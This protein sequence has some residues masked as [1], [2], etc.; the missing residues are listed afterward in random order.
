MED[1]DD[2]RE[3]GPGDGGTGEAGDGRSSPDDVDVE[4]E[5]VLV[6]PN[7][8]EARDLEEPGQVSGSRREAGGEGRGVGP[9][10]EAPEELL[11]ERLTNVDLTPPELSDEAQEEVDDVVEETL[12]HLVESHEFDET[13]D[14][15]FVA[16]RFFDWSYLEDELVERYWLNPP[17]A[18]TSV[19]YHEDSSTRYYHLSEPVL[20]DTEA[21]VL[22]DMREIVKDELLDES[23]T[24]D[25]REGFESRVVDVVEDYAAALPPGSRHKIAY[26]VSRDFRGYGAIDAVLRDER[27][28][29]ISAD[30]ADVPVFVYHGEYRDLPS[31]VQLD[32]RELDGLV[33]R[34][35]Q[36]AGR[37][38]SYSDPIV[39]ATLPGNHRVQLTL[40]SDVAPRG[41][42]FTVRLFTEIPFTPVDLVRNNTFSLE[43][44]AF[45]WLCIEHRQSILFVGPTASGKTTSM[46]AVSLFIEPYAK[47]VTIED[48][49]ELSMPHDNWVAGLTRGSGDEP[50]D[51]T[52]NDLLGAAL[53]QRPEYILVGEIRNQPEVLWT[54][55]QSVFTGHSGSTT[56]HA[57]DVEEALNR[58]RAEP[59]NLPESMIAALD[60]VSIQRQ[61]KI[62]NERRR[63]CTRVAELVHDEDSE[64][65]EIGDLFQR[66]PDTDQHVG[67][68]YMESEVLADLA[69]D[70]GW[71][72]VDVVE[73]L[74]RRR[75]FLEHLIRNDVHD[76]RDV[77]AALFAY[78]RDR[79]AVEEA[80][81]EGS[82]N[83]SEIDIDHYR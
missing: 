37:M 32:G 13:P 51:I 80:I 36:R 9:D 43:Q 34:L 31:N 10:V 3:P 76:Y 63:R 71:N 53:H 42:N 58:F 52:M 28:E 48:T 73:E 14:P 70:L 40:G 44:M 54:F 45:I 82:F 1:S 77:W 46:N 78:R 33:R 69:E 15:S 27:V 61:V 23:Y 57:T 7:Q 21:Y 30:G 72:D 24:E 47:V 18:Y 16:E 6:R 41:S 83:P 35:A 17:Y 12:Q 79:K 25:E 65:V 59:F 66:D 64:Q 68:N 26:H 38:I 67:L 49:R 56:F 11:E 4:P 55:L 22:E 75:S 19:M 8:D 50:H 2:Q 20:D 62:G 60:L 39:S 81:A 29:D 5:E 74:E